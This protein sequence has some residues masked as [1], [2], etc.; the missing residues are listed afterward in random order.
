MFVLSCH[1]SILLLCWACF[2]SR[3]MRVWKLR[4]LT[5]CLD[6]LIW[7]KMEKKEW[8]IREKM[9]GKGIWMREVGGEKSDGAQPFSFWAHHNSISPK[10]GENRGEKKEV[11]VGQ[12]CPSS[13]YDQFFVFFHC[14]CL[15]VLFFFFFFFLPR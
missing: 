8:K 11:F 14:F 7:G 13:S 10:W 5:L 2:F 6:G 15:S 4:S 9:S 12:N 3:L 1:K